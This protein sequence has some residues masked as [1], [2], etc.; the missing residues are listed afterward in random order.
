MSHYQYV[1]HIFMEFHCKRNY[2]FC[3]KHFYLY[4]NSC[5]LGGDAHL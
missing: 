2:T 3:M 1:Y 4:V 5:N